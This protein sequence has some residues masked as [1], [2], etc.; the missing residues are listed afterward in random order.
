M[1]QRFIKYSVLGLVW[2]GVFIE[3]PAFSAVIDSGTIPVNRQRTLVLTV[4]EQTSSIQVFD[5]PEL[6]PYKWPPVNCAARVLSETDG[7][8]SAKEKPGI[9]L[10]KTDGAEVFLFSEASDVSKGTVIMAVPLGKK[11]VFKLLDNLVAEIMP[12]QSLSYADYTG[13]L[14]HYKK[15]PE[16]EICLQYVSSI[17]LSGTFKL[18]F[19]QE[20]QKNKTV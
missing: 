9:F 16:L 1:F 20:D 17:K 13:I 7:K 5:Q 18:R 8:S 4:D 12:D 2:G 19:C 14:F 15:K 3:Q 10:V 11:V 6:N